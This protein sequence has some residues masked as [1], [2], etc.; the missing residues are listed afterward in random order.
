MTEA[1][2]RPAR[3]QAG[4]RF[5]QAV[6]AWARALYILSNIRTILSIHSFDLD[7]S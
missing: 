1:A 6:L 5:T 3:P 7:I 2:L 4:A